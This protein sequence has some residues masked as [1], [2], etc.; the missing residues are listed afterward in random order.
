MTVNPYQPPTQDPIATHPPGVVPRGTFVLASVGAW[1]AALYWAAFTLLVGLAV[2]AGAVSA[3]QLLLPCVLIGFYSVRGLQIFKGDVSAARKVTW[4]HV[5]GGAVAVFQAATTPLALLVALNVV[6][7]AVH[8][9]GVA[10]AWR[11]VRAAAAASS[12]PDGP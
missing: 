2:S 7:A 4:L 8:V 6:K 1:A 3:A 11:V 9:F 10:T 5:V 12:A